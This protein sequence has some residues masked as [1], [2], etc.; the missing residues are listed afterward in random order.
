MNT[1]LL[2]GLS[3]SV[4]GDLNAERVADSQEMPVVNNAFGIKQDAK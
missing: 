1:N 4:S 2:W 3:Q